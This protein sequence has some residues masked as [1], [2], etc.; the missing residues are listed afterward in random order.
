M[1][2]VDREQ[3]HRAWLAVA[4]ATWKKFSDD[5]AGNLAALIAYYAFASIFPL[6]LVAYSILDIVAQGS[7]TVAKHLT[8]ALRGYPVVGTTLSGQVHQGLGKTGVAL[9]IGI[10]LTLYASRGVATAMMNA[11]NTVWEVPQFRRPGFPKALLRSFGLIAVIGPGQ[12]ITI[13]LSSIAGGTGHL[14]G[15]AARVAAVAVSLVLNIGLFWL[16]FRVATAA[17]ISGR[18]MRLGAILSAIGWQILLTIGGTLVGHS[19][20]SAYGT[21]GIVLG[22][23]AFFY[24][25]AQLTLYFVELDAVRELRLWPRALAPPPLSPADVQAHQLY[26]AATAHRPELEVTVRERAD[27]ETAAASG[28]QQNLAAPAARS[29]TASP[30]RQ[31]PRERRARPR[32]RQ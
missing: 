2:A 14:G 12:L 15:V 17:Q 10:V 3:Q 9:A 20:N 23:L 22:L 5:Q 25:S 7:A 26:A 4:V 32:H 21:F 24:L 6:L 11:M 16:G 28:G 30:A 27:G 18:A 13:A 8:D 1:L 29:A 31:A 19:T